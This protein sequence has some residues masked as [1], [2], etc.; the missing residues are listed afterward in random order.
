MTA[1]GVI[2]ARFG[3]TR[4][5][6]KPLRPVLGKPLLQWVIEG[7]LTSRH[8][9]E[10]VVATDHDEIALLAEKAGV[11]AVMT[12]PDL[13]TGSDRVFYAVQTWAL[14]LAGD[15]V[16]VNIQGDEPLITGALLD[17][18][19][20]PF[21]IDPGLPMATLGR[22]LKAGDLESRNTAK[23]VL[24]RRGEAL[25]FSRF[26]IP[27]SRIDAPER[28][29][30]CL[31]HIGLYAFRKSFLAEFCAEPPT[32]LESAEG[33]EQLRALYL[34]ARIKVVPVEHES[35]GVDTP[36]DIAKVEALLKGQ[37]S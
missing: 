19:V 3:S 36:E 31:K 32:P 30:L 27:Y 26:P 21:F 5:P 22:A 2:P 13:A 34:G 15:D 4:F 7:A 18:L 11:R 12:P 17:Q 24:N 1:V 35:W 6:G 9:R 14:D 10:V 8:L 16:I 28:E 23:I 37:R 25:Y 33:L 20:E 29:A